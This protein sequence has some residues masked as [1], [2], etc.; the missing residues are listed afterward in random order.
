MERQITPTT[1]EMISDQ[2]HLAILFDIDLLSGVHQNLHK[3]TDYF[4]NSI[5]QGV[6][7]FSLSYPTS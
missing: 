5:N 7:S 2:R 6:S 3:V 1:A 4:S